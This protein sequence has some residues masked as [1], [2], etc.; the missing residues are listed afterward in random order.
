VPETTTPIVEPQP[1]P[2]VVEL[3]ITPEIITH[4]PEV[5]QIVE[6]T[7]DTKLDELPPDTPIMLD[8]GVVLTAEVVIAI[9]LLDDPVQ[10][11]GAIFTD[12]SQALM[13]ISNIGADMSPEVREKSQKVV[14]S[15]IIAGGIATQAAASAAATAAYRRKP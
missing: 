6:L 10:L 1:G 2:P 11:L 8:N 12:P 15:A 4:Q 5:S 9:Q 13:A 3:I 7:K 14:V